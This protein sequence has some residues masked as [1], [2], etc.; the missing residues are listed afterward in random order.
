M[1]T[2]LAY[3]V[4]HNGWQCRRL[5]RQPRREHRKRQHQQ[6][7]LLFTPTC[8]QKSYFAAFFT[9]V[10]WSRRSFTRGVSIPTARTYIICNSEK[11]LLPLLRHLFLCH[12]LRQRY[13]HIH[14]CACVW[15]IVPMFKSR[16]YT[17]F[18]QSSKW[19][20]E[21]SYFSLSPLDSLC[22]GLTCK[23]PENLFAPFC[24]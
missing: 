2:D 15:R 14:S 12:T 9:M 1:T 23:T 6:E 21:Q 22:I 3:F 11:E 8:P 20:T 17:E 13:M 18:Q 4:N 24:L 10:L 16:M 5:S 7:S 19:L